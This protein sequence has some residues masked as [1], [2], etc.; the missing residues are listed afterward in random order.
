M[1]MMGRKDHA[2]AYALTA[3]DAEETDPVMDCEFVF[4]A[5]LPGQGLSVG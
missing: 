2:G 1:E 5:R 4:A 3:P